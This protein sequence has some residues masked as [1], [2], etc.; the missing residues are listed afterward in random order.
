MKCPRCGYE[1]PEFDDDDEEEKLK[2]QIRLL[3]IELHG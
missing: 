3:D 2:E 1:I